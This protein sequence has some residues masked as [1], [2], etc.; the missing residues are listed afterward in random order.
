MRARTRNTVPNIATRN[1]GAKN[2]GSSGILAVAV[3]MV[4]PNTLPEVCS[5]E[6]KMNV[7]LD[8]RALRFLV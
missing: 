3:P 7:I 6:I 5:K 4:V 1:K 2:V 8:I